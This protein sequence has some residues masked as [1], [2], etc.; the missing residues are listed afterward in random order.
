MDSCSFINS[1]MDKLYDF[2][3]IDPSRSDYALSVDTSKYCLRYNNVTTSPLIHATCHAAPDIIRTLLKN[4]ADPNFPD[5]NQMT[6]A[7]H[8]ARQVL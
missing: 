6:A 4:G 2:P 7:M 5:S 3:P 1:N 8:A